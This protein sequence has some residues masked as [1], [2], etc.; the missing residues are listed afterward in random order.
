MAFSGAE[1]N[2]V[3]SRVAVDVGFVDVSTDPKLEIETGLVCI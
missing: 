1:G 3:A 2:E